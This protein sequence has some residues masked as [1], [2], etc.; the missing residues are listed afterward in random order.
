MPEVKQMMVESLRKLRDTL[1]CDILEKHRHEPCSD[2]VLQIGPLVSYLPAEVKR[3]IV[4]V[5]LALQL[6]PPTERGKA[7]RLLV[8]MC[9]LN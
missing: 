5:L 8:V 4:D 6:V 2:G 3:L 1:E 7:V 9:A